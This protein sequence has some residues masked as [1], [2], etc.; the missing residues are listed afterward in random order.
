MAAVAQREEIVGNALAGSRIYLCRNESDA[1]ELINK[2]APEHLEILSDNGWN[3]V[4]RIKNAGAIFIGRYSPAA[5]G[6]YVAGP[7]HTLPTGAASRFSSP[8]SPEIFLKRSSIISYSREGYLND[9]PI[10]IKI[11]EHE[12][13]FN[14]VNSL[15]I[16][17]KD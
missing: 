10:A 15:K 8:L 7:N 6:D 12:G 1:I 11:A 14:H 13:L 2:V 5:I 16:R 9:A 3:M 17:L 4:Y